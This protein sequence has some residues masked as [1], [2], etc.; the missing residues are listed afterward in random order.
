MVT[1]PVGTEE[2]EQA[3]D[4]AVVRSATHVAERLAY[5]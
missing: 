5:A 1:A 4:E 3:V 2:V